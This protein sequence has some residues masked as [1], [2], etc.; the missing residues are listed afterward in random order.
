[1]VDKKRGAGERAPAHE[2][3]RLIFFSDAVFAIA[4][5]LLV[6][7]LH[8]P[9]VHGAHPT[10]A[11]FFA[12]LRPMAPNFISFFVSF[13]VIGAFWSGHHRAFAMARYWHP[14]LVWTNLVL[15]S[16]VAAMPFL[17]AF[18]AD[19]YGRRVPAALY[20]GWLLLIALLNI[21]IQ[22][23][24][25]TPPVVGEHVTVAERRHLRQRG[26]SVVLAAATAL[27]VS[28]V[29]PVFAQPAMITIPLWYA[30]LRLLGPKS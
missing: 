3:E 28:L 27:A 10:D 25:T 7:E 26:V 8:V 2:L 24:A 12:A 14:R 20:C 17:T 22:Q 16:A 30:V 15:L 6:I 1:M 18:S 5:T 11:D 9:E 21:R 23:V 29:A 13:F 4:I 19:Y